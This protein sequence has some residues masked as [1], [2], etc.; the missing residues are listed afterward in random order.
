MLM[1]GSF[2]NAGRNFLFISHEAFSTGLTF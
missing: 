2:H 1:F